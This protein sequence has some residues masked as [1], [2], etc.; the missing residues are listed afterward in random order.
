M[1]G[2]KKESAH[3]IGQVNTDWLK[4]DDQQLRVQV[5]SLFTA[6]MDPYDESKDLLDRAE[7]AFQ[8]VKG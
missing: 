3:S 5:L 8:W 7:A 4:R 6:V 1:S 2:V